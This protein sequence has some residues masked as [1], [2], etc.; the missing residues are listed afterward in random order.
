VLVCRTTPGGAA[1]LA[2]VLDFG[3]LTGGDPATDLAAGW[4]LFG[5]S[6]RAAFRAHL[7]IADDATWQ[8]ARGWALNIGAAVAVNSAD[9]PAMAAIGAHALAQVLLED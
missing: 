6:G 8:R 5:P 7:T 1:R 2:A 3:D 9:N 4:L